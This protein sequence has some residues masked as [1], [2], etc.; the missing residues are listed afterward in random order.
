LT[1]RIDLRHDLLA[2]SGLS[3]FVV[4]NVVFWQS[5][6]LRIVLGLP[7]IV[8]FPGYSLV[9]ALFPRHDDLNWLERLGLSLALS[10]SVVSITGLV[11]NYSRWGIKLMSL[12]AL[13]TPLILLACVAAYWRRQKL[14]LA[15]R[16][17]LR[18]R[19]R[20]SRW[21]KWDG[22]DILLILILVLSVSAAIMAV[23]CMG[24][25]PGLQEAF[26]EFYV[27][28]PDQKL[29]GHPRLIAGGE[30]VPLILRVVNHE[31]AEIQ[32][33]IERKTDEG[34]EQIASP[35]L[36]HEERWEQPYTFTLTDPG[37]N[38]EVTFLLYREDDEEPY[39]SLHL[40]ITVKEEQSNR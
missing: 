37:E 13:L 18:V 26:T 11:L 17:A 6:A 1:L 10:V 19:I 24:V 2:L 27:L 4:L 28:G 15:E 38:R 14:V 30:S 29:G 39:R 3:I 5:P 32:Y 9:A 16:F 7:Y 33:H 40:W 8:L 22:L 25:L 31:H 21:G 34:T 36:G 12:L 20:V 35:R 23:I